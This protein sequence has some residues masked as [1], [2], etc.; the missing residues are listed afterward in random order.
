[1][2]T[3]FRTTDLPLASYLQLN[4]IQLLCVEPGERA[5]SVFVFHETAEREQFLLRFVNR[6][7]QVDPISFLNTL[8]TLK[9]LASEMKSNEM[10]GEKVNGFVSN[11]SAE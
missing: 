6:Q 2:K 9:A 4:G 5:R 8:R 7:G 1:M 11:A 3:E 10:I